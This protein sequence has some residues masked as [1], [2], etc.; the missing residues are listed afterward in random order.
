MQNNLQ[1]KC[2]KHSLSLEVQGKLFKIVHQDAAAVWAKTTPNLPS[3]QMKFALNAASDTL[4]HNANLSLWR[5]SDNL[6]AACK[7]CGD[8]QTLCHILNNYKWPYSYAD[9]TLGM[10][11]FSSLS[12]ASSRNRSPNDVT[13]LADLSEQYQFPPSLALSD[14]R[15]DLVAYSNLTKSVIIVELT[16]CYETNF[17]DA[18]AR[19]EEKYTELVKEVE[20]NG[21]VV[22]L[23][24]VE[25]G[26]RGFVNYESFSWLN[27]TL[28]APKKKLFDLL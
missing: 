14:L 5:K 22:D 2:L 20:E 21:F 27:S 12:P 1:N 25:V 3:A 16:V 19:K 24:T 18:R 4:P 28:G 13:V 7:L 6:A 17:R 26:S 10:M 15:P 23:I 11:T 8:R 9:T